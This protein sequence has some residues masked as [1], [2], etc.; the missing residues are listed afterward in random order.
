MRLQGKISEWNDARG[1]GFVQ[2]N[3]G[4]ERCFV[5]IRSFSARDRRPVLGDVITYD[6]QTD[7]QG[8]RNA[9]AVRFALDRDGSRRAART[10]VRGAGPD[11]FPRT[12]IALVFLAGLIAVAMWQ[13]WPMWVPG[14]YLG[15]SVVTFAWYWHDKSAAQNDR[16]RTPESRLQGLALLGGWPGALMAQA[17]LRHKNR[18]ASFQRVFWVAVAINIA[19]LGWLIH[20]GSIPG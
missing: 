10:A 1:F 15:L 8:R 12:A 14:A 6:V 17:M 16:Q 5:H 3:G 11:R 20:N 9:G 13:H 2:P 18:K 4:G 19:A 7:A